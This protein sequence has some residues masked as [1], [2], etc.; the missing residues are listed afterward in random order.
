MKNISYFL[1]EQWENS[2]SPNAEGQ[3]LGGSWMLFGKA[4]LACRWQNS[5]T[6]HSNRSDLS[7]SLAA[8]LIAI[9]CPVGHMQRRW[10]IRNV[11]IIHTQRDIGKKMGLGL[12]LKLGLR[13]PTK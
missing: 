7:F 1:Y 8:S 10:R 4:V 12:G 9:C 13:V 3:K 2:V 11:H 6:G 5:I